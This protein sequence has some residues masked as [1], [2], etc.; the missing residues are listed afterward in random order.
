[1]KHIY[2]QQVSL[3]MQPIRLCVLPALMVSD[4][5]LPSFMSCYC[6]RCCCHRCCCCRR[7][8][9]RC[10]CRHATPCRVSF[11]DLPELHWKFG[12]AYFYLLS[13]GVVALA[14]LLMV[15]MRL[16]KVRRCC[17]HLS[18]SGGNTAFCAF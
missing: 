13:I 17:V 7:C 4:T 14:L 10:C 2:L 3:S 12:Y 9:R 15:Y 18:L 5:L 6:G 16:I 1:L 8:C 11:D